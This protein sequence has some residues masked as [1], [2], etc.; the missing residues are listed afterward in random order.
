MGADACSSSHVNG[1]EMGSEV[2]AAGMVGAGSA[3][4]LD[5]VTGGAR[6]AEEAI[7]KAGKLESYRQRGEE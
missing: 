2:G 6:H 7:L 5:A 3:V 1:N 4:I